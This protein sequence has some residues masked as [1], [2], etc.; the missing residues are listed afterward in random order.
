[1][2]DRGEGP[3]ESS[4]VDHE[5]IVIGAGFGG[6]GSAIELNRAGIEDYVI[7]EK[8]HGV[9]GC[10]LANSYPGVAVDIPSFVYSYSYEQ[11]DDWSR[12]F[13]PGEELRRYA[14]DVASKH[15][16]WW[17]I[18][19]GTTVTSTAFDEISDRWRVRIETAD[20]PSELTARWVIAAVGPLER[21]ALPDIAGLDKFD[22]KV[23]H[24]ARW[25]SDYD[26]GGKRVAVIGTGASALQLIP[27]IA[28]DVIQLDVY[29][30]TPIW[31]AP[32]FDAELSRVGRALLGIPPVR[33]GLRAAGTAGVDVIGNVMFNRHLRP[34]ATG[35]EAGLRRWMRAQVDNPTVADQLIPD[36][37]FGC[38]RPS[39]SNTYLRSF[40][41]HNV[42]LVTSQIDH[43]TGNRI[44]TEDGVE[45]LVDLLV[46]ATGFKLMTPGDAVPY[47]TYGRGGVELGAY[48]DEHRFGAYQGVSVPGFPNLFT[49]AGPYGFVA[50]SYFWMLESTA[51]HAVRVIAHAR[52][53]GKTRA[54]VRIDV[55]DR[56]VDKCRQRQHGGPLFSDICAGSNTY[57][58]NEQGDSP[59]RPSLYAEM[60]WDNRH[61]PLDNYRYRTAHG[62]TGSVRPYRTQERLLEVVS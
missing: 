14:E 52:R 56:Y 62:P 12:V 49:I 39:M 41:R 27:E 13:A 53:R 46:C 33:A 16:L 1:M 50:G 55:H 4:L 40:N 24:T 59:I 37:G 9:G 42:R 19:F 20:G 28:P 18:Q 47:P 7:L 25:E 34:L 48:W 38:K 6:L 54:E 44:V 35:I 5:V 60:W 22:G 58:V 32:K 36:Y 11:R 10:W 30:R 29:Q 21:P 51:A 26:H 15:G 57:Y 31:V 17:H 61:F 43:V 3:G 23:M 2:S 8:W 45:R